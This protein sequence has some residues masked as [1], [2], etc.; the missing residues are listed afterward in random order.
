MHSEIGVGECL[1]AKVSTRRVPETMVGSHIL[2]HEQAVLH[3]PSRGGEAAICSQVASI[4][5]LLLRA[6]VLG[7][8]HE[9]WH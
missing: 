3:G 1:L 5:Y 8:V 6:V 2:Q 4:L 7:L 9:A